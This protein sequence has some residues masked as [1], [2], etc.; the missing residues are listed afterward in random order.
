MSSLYHIVLYLVCF[1]TLFLFCYNSRT[2]QT[3]WQYNNAFIFFV[4]LFVFIEGSRYGRGPDWMAYKYRFE[5]ISIDE[6]QKGFL[7]YMLLLKSLGFN[8]I[9]Y[10]MTNAGLFIIGLS[11]FITKTYSTK[12]GRWMPL[13][14][15]CALLAHS[16]N[17]IRQYIAFPFFLLALTIM[18][19]NKKMKNWL[20]IIIFFIVSLSFHFGWIFSIP[21]L[22]ISYKFIK[23]TVS[24][25][26][27]IPLLF[28]A[29]YIIPSGFFSEVSIYWMT[30][31]L[32]L[33]GLNNSD[34]LGVHYIENSDRWLGEDSILEAAMQ[35]PLTKFLQ[36][37]FECGVIIASSIALKK[38]P[39][40]KVLFVFNLFLLSAF[41]DRVMFG[42][43][44]FQ[45]IIRQ[46]YIFWFIP[47][48]YALSVYPKICGRIGKTM[49]GAI[50]IS[51]SY[52][53]LYWGRWIFFHPSAKY[54]WDV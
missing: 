9:L 49:L 4:I 17:E 48:G 42:Y 53:I 31:L 39:N 18:L 28:F 19:N 21:L 16:E 29:Y 7:G 46:L 6:S 8:Y 52:L 43:E 36:F 32:K 10:Y 13:F 22:V 14:A 50:I 11:Y 41:F 25:W 20:W 47:F 5:H 26:I 54:V 33:L 15:I 51:I 37:I 38:F 1:G 35:T 45:R 3:K 2:N 44:I 30:Q 40:Q 34:F 23:K 24:P 12:E 27:S